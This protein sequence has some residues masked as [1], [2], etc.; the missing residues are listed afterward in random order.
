MS[1]TLFSFGEKASSPLNGIYPF[2]GSGTLVS[3]RRENRA[4]IWMGGK[5][6]TTSFPEVEWKQRGG[7]PLMFRATNL[8]PRLLLGSRTCTDLVPQVRLC[9]EILVSTGLEMAGHR[10]VSGNGG[11]VWVGTKKN[12]IKYIRC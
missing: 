4:R 3:V 11:A 10:L 6:G 1:Q 8:P 12:R 7:L 5:E 9:W 2:A